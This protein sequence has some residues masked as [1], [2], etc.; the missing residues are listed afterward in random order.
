VEHF[1]DATGQ[2][3]ETVGAEPQGFTSRVEVMVRKLGV[4]REL[5]EHL[6]DHDMRLEAL[7]KTSERH[8][9]EL[10]RPEPR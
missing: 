1:E 2:E 6:V 7:E 8:T 5:A 3:R 9:G 4:S 10:E